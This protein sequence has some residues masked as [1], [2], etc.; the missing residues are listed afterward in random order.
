M[1]FDVDGFILDSF[2]CLASF[3]LPFLCFVFLYLPLSNVVKF[4][5]NVKF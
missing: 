4:Q 3:I 1:V 2:V 5:V